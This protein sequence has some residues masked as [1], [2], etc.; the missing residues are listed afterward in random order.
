M[1]SERTTHGDAAN[2]NLAAAGISADPF[3]DHV[4]QLLELVNDLVFSVS[5]DSLQVLY[6]NKAAETIYGRPL[7][8]FRDQKDLWLDSI[9]ELDRKNLLHQLKTIDGK[10]K[11]ELGFRIV[12]PDGTHRHL[13]AT[14]WKVDNENGRQIA[15][16]CIAK[17]ITNRI[18]REHELEESKAIYHSLVESLP[19]N[20]FRKDREGRLVF[21][22]NKCCKTFGQSRE[23]LIGKSDH[24][25]FDPELA[26]KYQRDDKWVLQT[27][28]PF[29]D[30]E[31]HPK[32]DDS[33]IYV[34]VLKSPV[35]SSSGRRIGIQGM[36]WDVT[37][38][39][40]AEI[41]LEKAKDIA[42]AA[43]QAKS[44]FLANVSHEIRTPLNAVIGITDLLIG[45][46]VDST[47]QDYLEMIRDS[48]QSLL[49]L[50]NDIL[51]F[52]KIESG[53]LSIDSEWFDVRERVGDTLRSL[54]HKAHDRNLDLI[55]NIDP[56][57]PVQVL[58]DAQR[59][60]QVLVNLV[61]N[62]I[63]FTE[64]G[65]VCVDVELVRKKTEVEVL[66]FLVQDT[67]I[68]I[69][70]EKLTAIFDEFV[71]VDTSST[72]QFGGTGLGLAI[73]S[74]LV[75]LM[76]GKLE[77]AS[78]L[79]RGSQF[80]FELDFPVGTNPAIPSALEDLS[81]IPVLIMARSPA[82]RESLETILKSWRMKTFCVGNVEQAIKLTKGMS[83][84]NQPIQIV[85]AE[86]GPTDSSAD[87]VCDCSLLSYRMRQDPEIVEPR[88]IALV[89]ASSRDGFDL[90][91]QASVA[92]RLLQPVK[93][94]ELRDA[95]IQCTKLVAELAAVKQQTAVRALG[96][97][98]ILLAEDNPVN[99]KLAVGILSKYGH[100]IEVVD[101]GLKAV[102]AVAAQTFDLVLMDV[103]MPVMDGIE[104]VKQIR[105]NEPP[106]CSKVP[107][108]AM[109][110]HALASDRQRCLE[111][112]MDDYLSKP[113]KA[114]DLI[115]KINQL[116]AARSTEH[117]NSSSGTGNNRARIDWNR[118][119]ET[120][121]GDRNLLKE[122]IGVFLNERESMVNDL[123]K[124]IQNKDWAEIRRSAHSLKGALNHLGCVAASR[125]AEKIEFPAG[126]MTD[127][128]T[129]HCEDLQNHLGQLTGELVR[130]KN[131]Q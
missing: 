89:R 67:G 10:T 80:F 15:F 35:T 39:K 50:I 74:R 124:A 99:Q 88:F 130:F 55:C 13:E 63:K 91:L 96:P 131:S 81:D 56:A 116:V 16:A 92:C 6:L 69:P 110:A 43:S 120:V 107:I 79:G 93:H 61:G 62:S 106:G 102:A 40:K 101:N 12:Q 27:G 33:Y 3:A 49:T 87:E 108:I 98:R 23:Q 82:N 111:A 21:V 112:G 84:A 37:D 22:N 71:Q 48:G 45:S 2:R 129:L 100:Q 122:L 126:D 58:G 7:E 60:R 78:Q 30:I 109:T 18:R 70:K 105:S 121:G 97:Y 57:I 72:R 123:I 44:D 115:A 104:A 25:L 38:R 46:S 52:S 14:F 51:D 73:A 36:F 26:A 114:L 31:F 127:Q 90:P 28:L 85:L 34:E 65:E 9:H 66:K 118:A 77:V 68:G 42:E 53:T 8:E 59:L 24:D 86:S 113:F 11:F 54:A 5:A 75:K 4:P 125:I 47:Q 83:F 117:G 29:H 103:Q 119:F 94:S 20:V 19:I 41:S 95:I 1:G 128:V 64:R 76:G 32:E 17:D